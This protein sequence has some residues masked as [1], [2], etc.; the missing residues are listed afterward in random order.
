MDLN[1]LNTDGEPVGLAGLATHLFWTEPANLALVRLLT[2]DALTDLVDE[3]DS[4]AGHGVEGTASTSKLEA[5][6]TV[7]AHLF[8]RDPCRL[9][10]RLS[11]GV[12]QVASPLLWWLSHQCH[13]VVQR[14]CSSTM[15]K[16]VGI[17]AVVGKP[18]AAGL[19][20]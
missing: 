15:L 11:C 8:V 18:I 19:D 1:L 20:E 14:L 16:Y 7:L 10:G 5:L 12:L 3:G 4:S 9:G 6:A 2:S 17:S 13:L